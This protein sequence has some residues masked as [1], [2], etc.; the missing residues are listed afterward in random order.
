MNRVAGVMERRGLNPTT[1]AR[2][3]GLSR[4]AVYRFLDPAYDPFPR[5]FRRVAEVLG[6]R[7]VGLVSESAASIEGLL[8][9][10]AEAQPRAFEQLPAAVASATPEERS[11]VHAGTEA[12]R[13]LLAAAGEF[14]LSVNA[15]P[16]LRRWVDELARGLPEHSPFLF[17][18]RWMDVA[19][20]V[21][22]TPVALARHHV[23]GAFDEAS[24]ARHFR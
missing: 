23:Y 18:A 19:R 16:E 13:R 6:V 12:Q 1:L 8:R 14:A 9:E 20:I 10:A 5:G 4:Q 3:A 24:L 7:P 2:L 15:E 17:G 11:A 21:A 22:A